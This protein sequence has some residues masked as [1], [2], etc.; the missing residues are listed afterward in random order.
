MLILSASPLKKPKTF[1]SN[2]LSS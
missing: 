2:T 1:S